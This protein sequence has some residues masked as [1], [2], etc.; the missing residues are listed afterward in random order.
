MRGNT[1][2]EIFHKIAIKHSHCLLTVS[3]FVTMKDCDSMLDII[4]H[5]LYCIF[6]WCTVFHIIPWSSQEGN[7]NI[8][9][10]GARRSEGLDKPRRKPWV[11]TVIFRSILKELHHSQVCHLVSVS[12]SLSYTPINKPS[13]QSGLCDMCTHTHTLMY[14]YTYIQCMHI[15]INPPQNYWG[16]S[17]LKNSGG[18]SVVMTG[19]RVCCA[20]RQM[21][22]GSFPSE[23]LAGVSFIFSVLFF[24][25]LLLPD[26]LLLPI[27]NVHCLPLFGSVSPQM[28]SHPWRATSSS[29]NP[30][31][32]PVFH[33]LCFLPSLFCTAPFPSLFL[34][35]RVLNWQGDGFSHMQVHCCN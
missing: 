20:L 3:S 8:P 4:K 24:F 29:F 21:E 6:L 14:R 33:P 32:P 7:A 34:P 11:G 12:A 35:S 23:R 28:T 31:P 1:S 13:H 22:S 30:F 16:L 27:P 2:Q 26:W 19:D 10:L 25:F 15:H 9:W 18:W 5:W 17:G